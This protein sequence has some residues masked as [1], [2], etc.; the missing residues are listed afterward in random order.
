MDYKL[1]VCVVLAGIA[2][3]GCEQVK[4]NVTQEN[5]RTKV[6]LR[7]FIPCAVKYDVSCLFDKADDYLADRRQELLAQA[8]AEV[9]TSGRADK[10]QMPSVLADTISKMLEEL[11]GMLKDGLSNLFPSA[12]EAGDD[13][14]VEETEVDENDEEKETKKGRAMEEGRKKEKK[15]KIKKL[16]SVIKFLVLGG[17]LK[18]V[19]GTLLKLFH[20]H[21]Q[22]KFLLIA[23]AGLLL[24]AA[25]FWID[26][27]KGHSPQKVIYYEHAQH[28]HHYEGEDDWGH[29]GPEGGYWG[30]AYD[31]EDEKKTAQDLAYANQRPVGTEYSKVDNKPNFSWLG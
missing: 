2:V 25:R 13:D 31:E 24:N 4:E 30:R 5:A 14:E 29:S 15:K 3:V 16:I 11:T 17:A 28:Q 8:D 19:I 20:A 1:V 7:D 22:V 9:I 18:A 23:L 26:L 10:S 27:K 6:T 12:K 21:L